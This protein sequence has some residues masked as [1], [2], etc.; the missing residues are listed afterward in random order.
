MN[1]ADSL[2]K[3]VPTVDA[4][5]TG[6]SHITSRIPYTWYEPGD[7]RT[8]KKTGYNYITGSALRWD[9]SYAEEKA[10]PAATVEHI[11]VRFVG[12]HDGRKDGRE[13]IYSV[14]K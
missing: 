2:R 12:S 4:I 5:F 7:K 1:K 11:K 13:Q 10:K 8:L 6:H 3:I 14:I 9:G